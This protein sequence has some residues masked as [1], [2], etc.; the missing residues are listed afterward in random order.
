MDLQ[1]YTSSTPVIKESFVQFG[2]IPRAPKTS[3]FYFK[4]GEL[5]REDNL[6]MALDGI[7]D[8]DDTYFTLE[9][10]PDYERALNRVFTSRLDI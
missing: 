4:L 10:K 5:V 8:K 2:S 3:L 1:D 9:R 7:T 6:L